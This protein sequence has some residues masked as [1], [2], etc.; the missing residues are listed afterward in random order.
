MEAFIH[1]ILDQ[2]HKMGAHLVDVG[3]MPSSCFVCT[4]GYPSS[5]ALRAR[6]IALADQEV[7]ESD[8]SELTH[9]V[10]SVPRL[11]SALPETLRL[12]VLCEACS[13]VCQLSGI[14]CLL[15]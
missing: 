4:A 8:W 10:V 11:W 7:E 3:H 9:F 2:P 6:A 13:E 5:R 15:V 1:P 12:L 14:L